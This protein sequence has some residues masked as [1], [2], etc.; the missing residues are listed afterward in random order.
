MSSSWNSSKNPTATVMLTAPLIKAALAAGVLVCAGIAL[1]LANEPDEESQL[2]VTWIM[3]GAGI[4]A[5]AGRLVIPGVL[6][7]KG[8]SNIAASEG[9]AGS[10][11]EE[12][13]PFEAQLAMLFQTQMIVGSALLEG[14]AFANL[15]AYFIESQPVSLVI[16]GLLWVALLLDFPTRASISA[17]I[18]RQQRLVRDERPVVG[19]R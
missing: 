2:L 19:R 3:A 17:W 8:R 18:D 11:P 4:A 14:G 13:P 1:L 5:L 10:V 15:A 9:D 12:L 16:A 7:T 6:V